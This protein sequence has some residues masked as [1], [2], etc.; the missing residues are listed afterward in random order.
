MLLHLLVREGE[1]GVAKFTNGELGDLGGSAI[2]VDADIAQRIG[3]KDIL[4]TIIVEVTYGGRNWHGG[5][6]YL[7]GFLKNGEEGAPSAEHPI[8]VYSHPKVGLALA[9]LEA[10][11]PCRVLGWG[12]FGL[13]Y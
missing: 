3:A 12:G 1:E 10:A 6:A 4:S 13:G 8:S 7:A 11:I 9:A 5:V 2:E